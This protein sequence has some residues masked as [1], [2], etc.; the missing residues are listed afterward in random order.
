MKSISLQKR[1]VSIVDN[2]GPPPVLLGMANPYRVSALSKEETLGMPV[3][4][5]HGKLVR[6][7]LFDLVQ[8]C[9]LDI[10]YRCGK[11]IKESTDC[12]IEHKEPW[13]G[14]SSNLF[15]DLNNIAF[16]HKRC[17]FSASRKGKRPW[18][19]IRTSPEAPNGMAWCSGHQ[20]WLPVSM[21]HINTGTATGLRDYCKE[22]RKKRGRNS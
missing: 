10:C 6:I 14:I 5:A 17:N 15:F 2:Y 20:D 7:V 18:L 19:A 12:T 22:C 9:G 16:S 21:F 4:K 8:K 3:G 11:V 1:A 13:L